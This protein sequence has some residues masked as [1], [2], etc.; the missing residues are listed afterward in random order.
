MDIPRCGR[1][2]GLAALF[3]LLHL[4]L[5]TQGPVAQD[6]EE[7]EGVRVLRGSPLLPRTT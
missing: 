1:E 2:P 7:Q 6:C 4:D 3:L 5:G